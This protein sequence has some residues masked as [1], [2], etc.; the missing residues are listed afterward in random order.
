[1]KPAALIIL[2]TSG[3]LLTSA[4]PSTAA[5]PYGGTIF[6]DPDIITA[7]DPTAEVQLIFGP[8]FF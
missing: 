3:L 1:M 7:A 5:P 2:M 6:I 8:F 4:A